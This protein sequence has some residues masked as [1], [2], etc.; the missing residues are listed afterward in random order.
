MVLGLEWWR[1]YHPNL[2]LKKGIVSGI[3]ANGAAWLLPLANKYQTQGPLNAI[4]DPPSFCLPDK[5]KD[6][7]HLF[8]PSKTV[9]TP[10]TASHIFSFRFLKDSVLPKGCQI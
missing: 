4:Q 3:F 1:K 8:E 7:A 2:D 9:P 5:F 6:Y 10:D